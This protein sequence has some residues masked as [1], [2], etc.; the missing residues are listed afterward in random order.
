MEWD[1]LGLVNTPFPLS[2][3]ILCYYLI[4]CPTIYFVMFVSNICVL[5]C[6]SFSEKRFLPIPFSFNHCT[7]RDTDLDYFASI[8]LFFDFSVFVGAVGAGIG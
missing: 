7:V 1:T 2:V 4:T 8:F 5:G 6:S 3:H